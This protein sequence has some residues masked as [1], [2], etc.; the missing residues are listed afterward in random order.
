MSIFFGHAVSPKI[1]CL[2][3][4]TDNG[5]EHADVRRSYLQWLLRH[6]YYPAMRLGIA[7][8]AAGVL[9]F[10]VSALFHELL[11]GLPLHMLRA[12]SF[13]GIMSQVGKLVGA[14]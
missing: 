12:W 4:C 6:V 1:Y 14:V 5:S 9:V 11:V 13:I 8:H 7:K 3:I 2:F 10:L